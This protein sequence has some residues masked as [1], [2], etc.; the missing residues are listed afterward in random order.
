MPAPF[1]G[2]LDYLPPKNAAAPP[3]GARVCVP[4]GARKAVPGVVVAHAARSTWPAS[5]LRRIRAVLDADTLIPK[6]LL[7][8]LAFAAR[9]YHYPPGEALAAVLPAPLRRARP[10]RPEAPA[11]YRWAAARDHPTRSKALAALIAHLLEVGEAGMPLSDLDAGDRACIRR[12][13]AR[14]LVEP[15]VEGSAAPAARA[16]I[17]LNEAQ[18]QA[19]NAVIAALEDY[20][21]FLLEGVT[22]SGKTEV[23]LA[24]IHEA[25]AR[26]RQALV[27]VPE[28][29]LTP[30]LVARFEAAL[31]ASVAAYH[32]GLAA[33]E[34][35]RVWRAAGSG[36]A[37]VTIGTRSAIFL[38]L[39]R[40]GLIV[41]DEEH[42]T[43]LKQQ[44]GF[45]YHA[46]D[47]AVYRSRELDIPVVLG[48][49]TPSFESLA[50][51]RV[52]RYHRLALPERAGS[53]RPP[54]LKRVDV[55]GQRMEAGLSNA[56]LDAIARHLGAGDQVLIFLNRRG[57]APVVL[58]NTCGAPLECTR[59]S[60]RLT[61]HRARERLICHHCGAEKPLPEACPECGGELIALGK[62]TERLEAV[63]GE[64]FSNETILR[65]DRDAT[66]RRGR[67]AELLREAASGNARILVGTQML[68]K[69][70]D[71][72]ALTLVAVIDADQGLYGADFRAPERMAQ[73]VTQVAGRAGRGAKAG[74]V[75]IQTRHPDHPLLIE[76]LQHGYPAF[77][78][79]A[80]AEREATGLPPYGALALL[81]AEATQESAPRNFL[82]QAATLFTNMRGLRAVGPAPAPM[83]RRAGR[84]RYQLLLEARDRKTLQN[85]LTRRYPR[86]LELPAARRVRIALD[87]DPAELG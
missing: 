80:L 44:E 82:S 30:Q 23:Y 42:D 55:R 57:F 81:R 8:L 35:L 26:G 17:R 15:V 70:H 73:L 18:I 34:R 51:V 46:R 61:W 28:I 77:A 21:A 58:C 85:A 3:I 29:A 25:L 10:L 47:L 27:I 4:L 79:R 11:R 22:G 20:A 36:E 31:G 2:A 16:P 64:R 24:A 39:A 62:G 54:T 12:L 71:F 1:A 60:A 37:Q 5:R 87:V 78:E 69:G 84:Y 6:E 76:L 59:C 83:L 72:Q 50:N 43:S 67:L 33:G 41:V 9:Y 40:P 63:L 65:I 49:A 53:A 13:A 48:S 52:Q 45:R 86:V 7:D 19:A 32:S 74:E 75:L 56:L 68:A 38:P 66:R 14:G